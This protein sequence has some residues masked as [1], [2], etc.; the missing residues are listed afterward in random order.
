VVGLAC[1]RAGD[2]VSNRAYLGST[3][4]NSFGWEISW[5]FPES[6]AAFM[7]RENVPGQI[8]NSYNEG[9][10]LTWRLGPKYPDYIDG[11][12]LPFG[13]KLFERNQELMSTPPDSPEW[14]REA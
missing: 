12:A 4:L 1:L 10:Y 5:W 7:E 13:T 2:L 6:A 8:F 3:N 14:L 11:R 9:G